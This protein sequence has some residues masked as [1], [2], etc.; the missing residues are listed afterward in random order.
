YGA[1]VAYAPTGIVTLPAADGVDTASVK[2][3][4]LAG[5]STVLT[6][7]VRLDRTPPAGTLTAP[8]NTNATAVSLSLA[9]TDGGSGLAQ[10]SFSVNGGA[11][12][13]PVAYAPPATVPLPAID[14]AHAASAKVTDNAGNSTVVTQTVKL[15]RTPPAISYTIAAPTNAGSYDLGSNPT[16]TF[17]ATD[18][19]GVAST[20]ATLD[21]STSIASG[22]AVNLYTLT[23]G[24]HTIAIKATDGAGNLA[25]TTVTIQ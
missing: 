15:D 2:V 3:T 4:D 25:T 13:T 17:G 8:A 12:G 14:R 9:F 10:M 23:A 16:V 20:S 24:S 6:Q 1:R 7:S 18:L 5:N 11:Y 19:N 21:A 22:G